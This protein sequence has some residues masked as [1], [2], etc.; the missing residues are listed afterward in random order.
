MT[1]Y[2]V[3]GVICDSYDEACEVAGIETPAQAAAEE[4]YWA[5]EEAIAEQDAMEARGGPR[6]ARPF[7]D[8]WV[9]IP[10]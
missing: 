8:G 7:H 4:A 9:D 2:N 1:M 10:F 6:Y 5:A 3:Y